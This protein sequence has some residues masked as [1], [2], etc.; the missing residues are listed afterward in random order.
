[1]SENIQLSA[2]I[3]IEYAGKR[4]DQVLAKIF[5][6]YSRQCLK[7]WILSGDCLIDGKHWQPKDK[8]FGGERVEI[9]SI[10]A[11]TTNW[12]AEKLP[13]NILYEDESI[14][15]VNKSINC[16]VHPGSGNLSKYI[17]EC[18]II[19]CARTSKSPKRRNSSSV[20]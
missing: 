7:A 10:I 18:I 9:T 19:L 11:T 12:Q 4:L 1:M 6:D 20:R 2:I 14:I 15:V 3:P 17:S 8:V 16:V 5:A 13:L